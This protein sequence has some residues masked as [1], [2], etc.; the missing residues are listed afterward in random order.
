MGAILLACLISSFTP[1]KA[2]GYVTVV[3][4][5]SSI[6]S[7][8]GTYWTYEGA[9]NATDYADELYISLNA[10]VNGSYK[11]GTA[12]FYYGTY[13]YTSGGFSTVYGANTEVYGTHEATSRGSTSIAY[14]YDSSY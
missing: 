8:N 13:I 3:Y 4:Q 12:R 6:Y 11:T 10:Y 7:N 9:H 5:W 14:S 2:A 1:A